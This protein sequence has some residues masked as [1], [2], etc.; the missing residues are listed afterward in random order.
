MAKDPKWRQ[1]SIL[2]HL[3]NDPYKVKRLLEV[4]SALG[5]RIKIHTDNSWFDIVKE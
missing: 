2:E 1:P 4:L 3:L 5:L